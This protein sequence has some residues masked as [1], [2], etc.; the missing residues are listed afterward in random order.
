MIDIYLAIPYTNYSDKDREWI[1][2]TVN[3]ISGELIQ[4]G[5]TVLSPISHSHPIAQY[6]T[7]KDFTFWRKFDF[8]LLNI[9]KCMVII[10]IDNYNNSIGI[11][12]EIDECK[13]LNKPIFILGCFNI[14]YLLNTLRDN[15]L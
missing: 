15:L 4:N 1:F 12:S 3:R 10:D 5:Y 14:N 7:P 8:E 9:C 6:G 2:S 13:R 11:M